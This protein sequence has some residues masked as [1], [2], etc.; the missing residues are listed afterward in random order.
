VPSQNTSTK[1]TALEKFYGDDFYEYNIGPSFRS[2]LKY[3]DLLSLLFKPDSVVDVGCGRGT[4]LKAFKEKGASKLVGYDGMWNAQENMID[5]L[6]VFHGVDLNEPIC[7]SDSERYDLAMSLEV[8]EHLEPT[9]A[10]DFVESLT[11]LSDAVL[12]GAAYTKQGGTNHINEQP[13]TYW[14]KIF[15]LFNYVPYD[16]FRPIVWGDKEVPFWYQQNTF[17][18][19]RKNTPVSTLLIN[20]G[21]NPMQNIFFMDCVHPTLYEN[22]IHSKI[23]LNEIATKALIRQLVVRTIPKP[24]R[25]LARKVKG[26]IT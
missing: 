15:L 22:H 25:P 1:N 6:I 14:A 26:L 10:K 8:A 3:V 5:Q 9:S 23:I 17:L 21:Y 13:H 16:L 19:V 12:F 2:A 4:W 24:L 7:I 11:R 20:A 18:F